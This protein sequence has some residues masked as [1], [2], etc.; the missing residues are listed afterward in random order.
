[1][2]V[3]AVVDNGE[4]KHKTKEREKIS[5]KEEKLSQNVDSKDSGTSVK[6]SPKKDK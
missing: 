1:M 3:N 5:K 4:A 6:E 2:S